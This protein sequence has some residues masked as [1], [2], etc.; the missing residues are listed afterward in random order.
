MTL[1]VSHEAQ[2]AL[3]WAFGAYADKDPGISFEIIRAADVPDT[4]DLTKA[5]I[6][7]LAESLIRGAIQDGLG[8]RVILGWVTFRR[9]GRFGLGVMALGRSPRDG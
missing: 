9:E 1:E 6:D 3:K 2:I 5:V 4:L 8:A 7:E